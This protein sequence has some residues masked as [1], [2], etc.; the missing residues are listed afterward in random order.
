MKYSAVIP[1]LMVSLLLLLLLIALVGQFR[2]RHPS[3]GNVQVDIRAGSKPN[4]LYVPEHH[5]F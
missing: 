3:P 2:P 5:R 4:T 1:S